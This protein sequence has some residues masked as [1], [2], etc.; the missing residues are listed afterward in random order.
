[1]ILPRLHYV[2]INLWAMIDSI[3]VMHRAEAEF[4]SSDLTRQTLFLKKLII[5]YAI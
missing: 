4:H 5:V 3:C 1:M 2:F